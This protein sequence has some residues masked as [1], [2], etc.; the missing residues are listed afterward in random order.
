MELFMFFS[1][2]LHCFHL[3]VPAGEELPSLKVLPGVTLT[4]ESFKVTLRQR[5]LE[6]CDLDFLTEQTPTAQQS[7]IRNI[8]CH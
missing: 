8:G 1:S 4:P 6:E 7:T 3:E 5:P 2:L